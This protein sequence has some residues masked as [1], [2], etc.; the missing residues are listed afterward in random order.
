[1]TNMVQCKYCF[2]IYD[3]DKYVLCPKCKEWNHINAYYVGED[4]QFKPNRR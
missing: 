4:R 1:M 3:A 2:K